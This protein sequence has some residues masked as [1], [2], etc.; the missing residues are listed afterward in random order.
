MTSW[1]AIVAGP[2][3]SRVEIPPVA[4]P[5]ITVRLEATSGW[6]IG[7][8]DESTPRIFIPSQ[9]FYLFPHL[10]KRLFVHVYTRDSWPE[11]GG[12]FGYFARPGVTRKTYKFEDTT[13]V[14]DFTGLLVGDASNCPACEG[15][16]IKQFHRFGPRPT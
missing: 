5:V 1:A 8:T 3:T 10:R 12:M 14:I 9:L 16:M 7:H 15:P 2:S 11:P 13:Y 6:I 4:R